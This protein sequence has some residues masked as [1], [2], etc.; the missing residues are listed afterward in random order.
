[1]G[2]T[3]PPI[4]IEGLSTLIGLYVIYAVAKGFCQADSGFC[5]YGWEIFGIVAA[6]SYFYLR[7]F[8]N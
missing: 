7:Y 8:K 3:M 1:M 4:I 5:I 2:N 6:G